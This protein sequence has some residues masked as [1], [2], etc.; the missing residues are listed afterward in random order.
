MMNFKLVLILLGT[1][2]LLPV[3]YAEEGYC[4]QEPEKCNP[5]D[6]LI[7]TLSEEVAKY[8]D[9]D[10][11]ITGLTRH[12]TSRSFNNQE[13]VCVKLATPRTKKK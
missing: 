5:G 1:L 13:V 11:Q 4:Y 3:A 6:V 8:C 12:T 2:Y 9:F 10:K 7:L